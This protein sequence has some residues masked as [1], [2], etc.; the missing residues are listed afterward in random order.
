[1]CLHWLQIFPD[2][3]L[4]AMERS[5]AMIYEIYAPNNLF[6]VMVLTF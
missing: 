6:M 2:L 3:A 4:N 5:G 1:M